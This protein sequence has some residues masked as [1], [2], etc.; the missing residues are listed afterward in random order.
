MG[1]PLGDFSTD[2]VRTWKIPR[3]R[4]VIRQRPGDLARLL[5]QQGK[6][7]Q[8]VDLLAPIYGWF[9]EGFDLP[10]LMEVKGFLDALRS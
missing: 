3:R 4:W 7:Q 5:V 1:R 6:R 8:A 9:T 2:G 10:D